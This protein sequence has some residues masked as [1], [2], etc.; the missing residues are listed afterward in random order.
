ME[1]PVGAVSFQVGALWHLNS[2]GSFNHL[3]N[4]SQVFSS[5]LSLWD[6]GWLLHITNLMVII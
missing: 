2:L 4:A 5:T 1:P 6:R 3:D